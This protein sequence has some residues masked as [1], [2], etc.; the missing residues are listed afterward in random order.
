MKKSLMHQDCLFLHSNTNH[1]DPHSH[2]EA[3]DCDQDSTQNNQSLLLSQLRSQ[4]AQ[5]AHPAESQ[6]QPP[7]AHPTS[8]TSAPFHPSAVL[9]NN[10]SI[11]NETPKI[12]GFA[13]IAVPSEQVVKQVNALKLL[14]AMPNVSRSFFASENGGSIFNV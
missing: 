4:A 6:S 5:R 7:S 2:S 9:C 14:S 11:Y 3:I 12:A 13:A 8:Q 1:Q 10:V